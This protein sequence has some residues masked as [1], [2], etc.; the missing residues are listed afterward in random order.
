MTELTTT[1]L[2]RASGTGRWRADGALLDEVESRWDG[3]K[4]EVLDAEARVSSVGFSALT[5]RRRAGRHHGGV[6]ALGTVLRQEKN[7]PS[8]KQAISVFLKFASIWCELLLLLLS[9]LF[10]SPFE[11]DLCYLAL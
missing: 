9:K 6:L 4:A 5:D 3:R 8:P 11:F 1:D 7:T 2:R 10:N